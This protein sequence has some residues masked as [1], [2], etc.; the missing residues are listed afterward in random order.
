[1]AAAE[2]ALFATATYSEFQK[3][4]R[5]A[6]PFGDVTFQL[7]ADRRP[8]WTEKLVQD[9][10]SG[11]F[12]WTNWRLI[13]QLMSV[14]LARKP[15]HPHYYLGMIG[16]IVRG[17]IYNNEN[18]IAE[19]LLAE[20]DLLQDEVWRLFE[21]DGNG[22]NSLANYDRFCRGQSWSEA[23]VSLMKQRR[24]PRTTLQTSALD[25]LGRDFN[26]YRARWFASFYDALEPTPQEL[27]RHAERFLPLL[28]VS[29]PNIVTWAFQKV[30]SHARDGG[31]D[32]GALVN[33]LRPALQ[34]RQKGIVKQALKLLEQTARKTP[35]AAVPV[36][37]AAI[38]ALGNE[39]A[40][41][42]KAALDL[43]ERCGNHAD[44]EFA[45]LVAEYASVV[46]PSVRSRLDR[47]MTP[48]AEP[49]E[50][51]LKAPEVAV[52]TPDLMRLAKSQPRLLELFAV[53]SLE[54]NLRQGR[55]E[56]PAASFDGM[57]I[58]RLNAADRLNPVS[59]LDEL[60]DLCARVVEDESL[61]DDAE[62]AMDGLSRL[63]DQR[64]DDFHQRVGPLLK[65]VTQRLKKDA[66]P[67]MGIGPGDD[68][69][70]L[71]Y[72][73]VTGTVIRGVKKREHGHDFLY[74]EVAGE[75]RRWF[76]KNLEKALGFLSRRSLALAERLAAGT[77]ALLLSAPTHTGG[78][79]DPRELA[80]RVDELT[81]DPDV[82]DVCLAM[83]RLAP[84][85]RADAVSRLKRSSSEWR[86]ALR[87]ALG[88]KEVHIGPTAALWVAAA[89][90]R[91]AWDDD[92][93]V[94]QAFPDAG[95]DGGRAAGYSFR[96][97]VDKRN[98]DPLVLTSEPPPPKSVQRDCVTVVLHAQRGKG[99]ELSYELGGACGG[100]VGSVRWSASIW[101][102][103]RESYFA[104]AACEIARNLDWWEASWQNKSLLE[105][106]LD[107]G[108]P[109]RDM[110]RLLLTIA[111]AAKDPGEQGL[112][113]D[114]AI[115]AMDDGRLGTDNWG[116]MLA[117]LL[118][119]GLIKPGRWQK[120]LAEVARVSPLHAC[121]VQQSLQQAFVGGLKAMPKDSAKLLELLKELSIDLNLDIANESCRAFLADVPGKGKGG[122]LARELLALESQPASV[123]GLLR[124]ALDQR[125]H[126]VLRW[127]DSK[128]A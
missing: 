96:V 101:P 122:K 84:D 127:S 3:I 112:A 93:Q 28:C 67:F 128:E 109:L 21:Y 34:Q 60:I 16:G 9:M 8:D 10:L 65:R 5:N 47:W 51:P 31:Y 11:P 94:I 121:V 41:V 45:T 25:A 50:T 54:S 55:L 43:I 33:A 20:P 88:A 61:V 52:I 126:A 125:L 80:R 32:A 62:Q 78:W 30:E 123:A 22:E 100:T 59:N 7:L 17:G 14:G 36:A 24:L 66:A 44:Q 58:P 69:C 113:T 6:R 29:A 124:R 74:F 73:W 108:T 95:P 68:L 86:Q 117:R 76:A 81:H 90:A 106:L 46:S 91:S 110:G 103:A 57:D 120:T 48:P 99:H 116:P 63:C 38:A 119:T 70:G 82:T 53:N 75:Q 4:G 104:T 77:A 118:P 79:I 83:L 111:L 1:M 115:A 35:E 37:T 105:P 64:P 42:Q 56:I 18:S 15:S 39:A 72:A 49:A 87:Y 40:D 92:D 71:V 89:R 2:V 26:H 19:A 13:R 98:I 97:S 107:P 27:R 85:G 114:I 12:Y 23:L 102:Q